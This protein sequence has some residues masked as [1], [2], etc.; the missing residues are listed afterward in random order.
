MIKLREYQH[1][2]PVLLSILSLRLKVSYQND[3]SV[4]HYDFHS[5]ELKIP[6]QTC[7][8]VSSHLVKLH[9]HSDIHAAAG[10]H[11]PQKMKV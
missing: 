2:L 7:E 11:F 3:P 5:M 10:R 9:F 1:W 6:F 8:Q 4:S